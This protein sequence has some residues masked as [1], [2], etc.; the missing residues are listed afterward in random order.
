MVDIIHRITVKAPVAKVFAALS[1]AQGVAGW[2]TRETSGESRPGGNLHV[3]FRSPSGEALGQ[4]TFEL[5]KLVPNESV[6]W[7]FTS[8]PEEWL[9]TDVTFNL[10][11]VGDDTLI[12]FGHR[13][14]REAVEFTAHCSMKWATFLLSLRSYA[15]TGAGQP[16][17]D[18][19][20]ID[21]WN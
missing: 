13:N 19:L 17:P 8:G 1:T 4:M 9:G 5:T 14:W 16:A 20:K 12:L 6:H 2:W 10:S 15:E 7:R 3:T 18:D 21:D 11:R